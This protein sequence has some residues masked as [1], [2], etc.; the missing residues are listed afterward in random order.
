MNSVQQLNANFSSFC[1]QIMLQ[2]LPSKA[3]ALENL[4]EHYASLCAHQPETVAAET[5]LLE[6]DLIS[7]EADLQNLAGRGLANNLMSPRT[8]QV[9]LAENLLTQY[10][11]NRVITT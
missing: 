4:K 9:S 5:G 10:L 1:L 3:A 8:S 2:E 6:R 7:L 11:C